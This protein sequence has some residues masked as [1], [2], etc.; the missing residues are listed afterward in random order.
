MKLAHL[1]DLHLGAG[2]SRSRAA[3]RLFAQLEATDVDHVVVT[4][5]VTHSGRREEWAEAEALF[6]PLRRSGRLTLVPGNHDR[7]NDDV[8]E[9]ITGGR[10]V[11]VERRPGLH[12]VCVDSTAPHNRASFRAHGSLCERTLAEVD[13]A[14]DG[15]RAGDAVVV[16][17][18]HHPI[19]LPVEGIGEWFADRFG[20]PHAAELPLGRRLLERAIGRAELVL[21]GHR[22]VPR[23]LRAWEGERPLQ[24]CNAGS[25]TELKAFRVFR[26]LNGRLAEEPGWWPRREEPEHEQLAALVPAWARI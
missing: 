21:H 24:V 3:A 26:L 8:A 18:H 6:E 4:G 23:R 12:L 2:R 10:R 19:P 16:L 22:H 20:W 13:H 7:G 25:S 9:R 1:S 14:L 5:D 17:L 11:W 15:A